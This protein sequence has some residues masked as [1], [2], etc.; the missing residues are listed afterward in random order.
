MAGIDRP[1]RAVR[2]VV[3]AVTPTSG[4]G[5]R[6][7]AEVVAAY[8]EHRGR[9]IDVRR[10]ALPVGV[11]GMWL[12]NDA[13]DLLLVSTGIATPEQTL[14]HELGHLVLDHPQGCSSD[15]D[16]GKAA[17]AEREAESFATMLVRRVAAGSTAGSVDAVVDELLG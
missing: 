14:A 13:R 16:A 8:A 7:I 1:T 10:Q 5:P 12:K 3:R 9:P 11:F 2:S 6:T 17:E 15:P 4:A